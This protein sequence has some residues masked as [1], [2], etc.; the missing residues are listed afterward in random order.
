M[1]EEAVILFRYH[2]TMKT[3]IISQAANSEKQF[4]TFIQICFQFY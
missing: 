3:D 1:V 2:E 4:I